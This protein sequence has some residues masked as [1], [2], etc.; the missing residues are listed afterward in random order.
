MLDHKALLDLHQKCCLLGEGVAYVV[1]FD[2]IIRFALLRFRPDTPRESQEAFVKRRRITVQRRHVPDM[3]DDVLLIKVIN[4]E[5][6][7]RQSVVQPIRGVESWL[8][9]GL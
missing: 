7:I 1:L 6:G 2:R 5:R 3:C 8:C 9:H 4:G